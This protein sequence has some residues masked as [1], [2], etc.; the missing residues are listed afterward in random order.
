MEHKHPPAVFVSPV[1]QYK[2]TKY[3]WIKHLT[4]LSTAL[5]RTYF[6]PPISR[7]LF[8]HH[9]CSA[10]Q[11]TVGITSPNGVIL[12]N[13]T[14]GTGLKHCGPSPCGLHDSLKSSTPLTVSFPAAHYRSSFSLHVGKGM[15]RMWRGKKKKFL[16]CRNTNM[17]FNKINVL[18]CNDL[19]F[20]KSRATGHSLHDECSRECSISLSARTVGTKAKHL[21]T[22]GNHWPP[23]NKYT[24]Y[25]HTHR[26]CNK[27]SGIFTMFT[28]RKHR[29]L[30]TFF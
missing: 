30:V 17:N 27:D 1:Q 8:K 29:S 14:Q 28:W 21:F 23:S 4:V 24:Q 2:D 13:S 22:D 5:L 18:C 16:L 3:I 15:F 25:T 6:F 26:R 19:D 12:L 10:L 11:P 7:P 9:W 20:S